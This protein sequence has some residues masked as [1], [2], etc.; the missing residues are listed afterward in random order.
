MQM[1]RDAS[2]AARLLLDMKKNVEDTILMIADDPESVSF[3]SYTQEEMQREFQEQIRAIDEA[4]EG[5]VQ[6]PQAEPV[7]V[8]RHDREDDGRHRG[9]DARPRK[10]ARRPRRPERD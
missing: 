7:N 5:L 8:S 3:G 1:V 10:F 9:S 6:P 4:L 2:K